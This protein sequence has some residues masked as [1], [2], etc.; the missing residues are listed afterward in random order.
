[1]KRQQ[2][3]QKLK[4]LQEVFDKEY[5]EEMFDALKDAGVNE[6]SENMIYEYHGYVYILRREPIPILGGLKDVSRHIHK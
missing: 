2:A 5:L 3:L 6:V 4:K 1:M